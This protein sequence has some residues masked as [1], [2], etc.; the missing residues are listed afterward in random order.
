MSI[1]Q[2]SPNTLRFQFKE[3]I[4]M[5]RY[6][7]FNLIY[8]YGVFSLLFIDVF[9]ATSYFFKSIF[10]EVL[11]VSAYQGTRI[12]VHYNPVEMLVIFKELHT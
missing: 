2:R 9:E 12:T 10:V 11:R 3:S 8:V 6:L 1:L 5:Y 4:V 7:E